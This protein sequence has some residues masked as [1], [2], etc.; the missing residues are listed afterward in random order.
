[1][2]DKR[3][4]RLKPAAVVL[5]SALLACLLAGCS[6]GSSSTPA[7]TPAPVTTAAPTPAISPAGGSFTSAQ[8]VTLT[9][10][11]STATIYYT[12]DATTP[13]TSSTKYTAPFSVSSTSTV[14]AIAAASGYNNSAAAV[15]SFTI[16]APSA[17]TPTL[18]PAPG[19][20]ASAQTVT[21]ADAT[22]GAT[23]YYTTDGSTPTTSSSKYTTP[24]SIGVGTTVQAIA[25]ASNYTNSATASGAYVITGTPV[26]VSV[27]LSTHDQKSLLAAQSSIGFALNAPTNNPIVVDDTQTYQTIEGFGAS[28]TDSAAYLLE[29]TVPSAS[30]AGV[31]SDLFTRSGAGIGLSFMR[32]PMGATDLARNVYTFD[33][34]QAGQTDPTLAQF[35]IAHDQAYVL[36]LIKAARTLNPQMK[37][38]ANPW[39]PPGWMKDTGTT[40]GGSLLPTMY[41]P[42]ANYF[43]KYLQAYGTAGVPI[44][45][46][47]LQNEPLYN[48]TGYPSMYMDAN[49][50]TTV[51]RD[52]VLPALI[53]N[54][55]STKIFAYDHNW[56]NE[57]Y[58]ETVLG[59]P[60]LAASPQV[61]GV[62]WHGYGGTPG[63][64]T[65]V[66]N[67]IGNKGTWETEHSGGTFVSDQFTSDFLEITQVLRNYGKAYV[68]WS[69]ALDQTLGP[70]LTQT[71]VKG[72]G[73]CATCTGIVSVDNTSGAVTKTVE[74]YTLGQYSKYVVNGA[75]RVYSS[76]GITIGTAAFVNPDGSHALIAFNNSANSQTFQVQWGVQSFS[77]TLP[78]YGAATFTWSG[79]ATGTAALTAGAEVQ[80][81]S[82]S[83]QNGWM[84]ENTGD[85][86]GSYDLGYAVNNGY[87]M[88]KGFQ[89]GTAGY[90]KVNVRTASAGNGGTLEFHLDSPTGTL[91]GT[92]TLPVT[93]GYQ[94]YQTVS[95]PVTG[96]TG[97]HDLY[98]VVKGSGGIANVNWF[99]FQ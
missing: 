41:T 58:P 2:T 55:L 56:D 4:F 59:D 75:Q 97:T 48:T 92:A 3:L 9:D 26:Q 25:V 24:L 77:Y 52:Y 27:V 8:T 82:Y 43:V 95:A 65:P 6:G 98:I 87:A 90:S 22:S 23:I 68:K 10:S 99:Q 85:T 33:D 91:L 37:L 81:S 96:A 7:P 12:T 83:M 36:P 63:A 18:S 62:A 64:Q 79:T 73:G 66:Q 38:M 39:S 31:F 46:I 86:T 69:L 21:L 47:S 61:A 28:F 76:N 15:A 1:M 54:N 16:T 70:N 89:F 80:A 93:G 84:T 17:A 94:T 42:F 45:Y 67:V 35:S 71:G 72:L 53:S 57:S 5:P 51:M 14:T 49:Q 19:T 50:Q 40:L 20:Y 34:L 78:A 13:T 11:L 30:Q 88:Y 74:Y 60:V 29:Q 32:I 44:D